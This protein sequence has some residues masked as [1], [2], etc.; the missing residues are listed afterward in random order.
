M[1]KIKNLPNTKQK[2]R[3]LECIL[4]YN[5]INQYISLKLK[6]D[7]CNIYYHKFDQSKLENT[8]RHRENVG[9]KFRKAKAIMFVVKIF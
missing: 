6:Y 2:T 3:C 8:D 4:F 5:F 7:L 9:K 1:E